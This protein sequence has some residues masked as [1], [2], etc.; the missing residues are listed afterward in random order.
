MLAGVTVHPDGRILCTA[1]EVGHIIAL[2]PTLRYLNVFSGGEVPFHWPV[3]VATDADGDV[4]VAESAAHRVTKVDRDGRTCAMWGKEGTRPGEFSWPK[5]VAV[6]VSGRLYVA[7]TNNSRL[8]VLSPSGEVL[9]CVG[10]SGS[11]PG[12]FDF[13]AAVAVDYEERLYVAD[14]FNDRIQVLSLN[15]ARIDQP[16]WSVTAIHMGPLRQPHA[17]ATDLL[18]GIVAV[19]WGNSRLV[20]YYATGG[21]VTVGSGSTP[22]LRLRD[23]SGV[24]VDDEGYM[25][26]T[27][28]SDEGWGRLRKITPEGIVIA[29]WL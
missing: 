7:D 21:F 26:V 24:A 1:P 15:P 27:D 23:P 8:Q 9:G 2:T 5:D 10:S 25:Y 12:E 17:I 18:G 16:A 3:G 13:P 11:E 20:A 28:V 29:E 6:G 22:P 4:Y 19:D 14:T